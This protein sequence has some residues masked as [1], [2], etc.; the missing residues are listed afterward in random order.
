MNLKAD[1]FTWI[2]LGVVII[3]LAAAVVTVNRT[4]G[5]G[6]GELTYLDENSPEAAIYNAFVA[7]SLQDSERV[8]ELYTRRVLDEYKEG[9]GSE[10]PI[11]PF[12]SRDDNPRRLR[13][14]EVTT[15]DTSAQV[16]FAVDHY[17]QGGPF[18]SGESWTDQRTLRVVQEEGIWK[19]DEAN[20][21]F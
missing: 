13:I 1:R 5:D 20:F 9:R 18:G 3:L 17:S 2:V 21:Y 10:Q 14:L 16:T 11:R 15:H 8:S 4:N 6:W 12:F 7:F 19:I